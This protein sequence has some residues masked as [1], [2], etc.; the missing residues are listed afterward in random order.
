[1]TVTGPGAPGTSAERRQVVVDTDTGLDDA[2]ALLHL[3]G[4]PAADVVAVTT[5]YGN[6]PVED[7]TRNAALVLRLAG[8]AEVPL[9]RGAAG[10]LVGEAH[11]AGYVHGDDGLGG[12]G[13]DRG[14]PEVTGP[15]A[16]EQLVALAAASPGRLDLLALGPLTNVALALRIDPL[17]LTR[18]RSVV[19]MGGSGTFQAPGRS[20]MVDANVQNDPA[21]A[22]AVLGAER[23]GSGGALTPLTMVGVDVTSTVV[24]DEAALARLE[25][26]GTAWAGFAAADLRAYQRFYGREWGRRVSPVHDGLAAGVLVRPDL[27]TASA[28]GPV[29]VVDNGY[30]LRAK[31]LL[32]PD[33]SP[34]DPAVAG[35]PDVLPAATA[36]TAV[37]A[38][39]FVEELL[40]GLVAGVAR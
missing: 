14:G 34:V 19:L 37:D 5:V 18:L 9:R 3:A 11:I 12:L 25:A 13:G 35:A 33:G 1:M 27:V 28:T 32:T 10:P 40:A 8:L 31:V 6:A 2:L 4:S 26:A 39:A 38:A 21:A 17:L 23:R 7:T 36:V 24:L 29:A 22:A 15:S 20:L 30:Q 16:A